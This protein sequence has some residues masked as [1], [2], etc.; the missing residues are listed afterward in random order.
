MLRLAWNNVRRAIDAIGATT[1]VDIRDRAVL[2]LLATTGEGGHCHRP[3]DSILFYNALRFGMT[4]RDPGDA[5]EERHRTR[6]LANL[7]RRGLYLAPKPAIEA[8]S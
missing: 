3:K 6:V 4:Y 8:V 2:L 5:Y 7:H 1:P